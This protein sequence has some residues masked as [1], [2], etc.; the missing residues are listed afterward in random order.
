MTDTLASAVDLRGTRLGELKQSMQDV[1]TGTGTRGDRLSALEDAEDALRE[2]ADR[3]SDRM[4]ELKAIL[5]DVG[6]A[7]GQRGTNAGLLR[8]TVDEAARAAGKMAE[9]IRYDLVRDGYLP[10]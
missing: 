4:A 9:N 8:E 10:G 3:K 7:A 5:G 1:E 2:A 6:E